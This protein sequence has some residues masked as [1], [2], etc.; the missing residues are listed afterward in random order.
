MILIYAFNIVTSRQMHYEILDFT[1][2][3]LFI[4]N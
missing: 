3:P 1:F 4:Y 2:I